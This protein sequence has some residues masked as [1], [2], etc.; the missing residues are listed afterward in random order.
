MSFAKMPKATKWENSS[1][2]P[3]LARRTIRQPAA[4]MCG[5]S[6]GSLERSTST[7]SEL[8]AEADLVGPWLQCREDL[9]EVR[10]VD[11]REVGD[12]VRIQEIERIEHHDQPAIAEPERLVAAH[13]DERH[14]VRPV[15][16][17]VLLVEG[18]RAGVRQRH[19]NQ[20]RPWPAAL[21]LHVRTDAE[22]MRELVAARQ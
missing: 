20:S 8:D 15:A 3:R 18:L 22:R 7:A 11:Q 14:G 4:L 9:V 5:R 16:A 12:R 10:A 1:V 6:R 2:P 19:R 17:D 21:D 13:P